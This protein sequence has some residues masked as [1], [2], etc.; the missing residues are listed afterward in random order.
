MATPPTARY[1]DALR[2]QAR[3]VA[4][5]LIEAA[6]ALRVFADAAS[7]DTAL[8]AMRDMGNAVQRVDALA[9]AMKD[10]AADHL[11]SIFHGM[12]PAGRA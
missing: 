4:E 2:Q 3:S 11:A 9:T 7:P 10:E 6:A 12:R 8:S 1:P 5:K